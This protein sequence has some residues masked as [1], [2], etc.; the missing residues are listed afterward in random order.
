M[1][2]GLIVWILVGVIFI[3]MMVAMFSL[4]GN[5]TTTDNSIQWSNDLNGALSK[6]QST[7]HLVLADVYAPWCGYC[8]SMDK[9]TF[10]DPRVQQKLSNY[11]LV[12]ING[13]QNSELM[14]K[15]QIYSYPTILILDSSGNIVKTIVGYQSPESLI[16]QI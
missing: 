2:S 4:V 1:K 6:A 9:N 15:Y 10:T 3:A 5:K 8:K 7:N 13:D 12:K 14:K 11:V 16:N